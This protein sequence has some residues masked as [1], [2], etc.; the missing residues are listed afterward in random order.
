[1]EEQDD[2]E[3]GN[4]E[5]KKNSFYPVESGQAFVTVVSSSLNQK[6]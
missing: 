4:R 5:K 2:G 3:R 6:K 1:M